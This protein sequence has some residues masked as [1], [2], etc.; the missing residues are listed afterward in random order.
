MSNRCTVRASDDAGATRCCARHKAA[1]ANSFDW[2][3]LLSNTLGVLI[4][5][6]LAYGLGLVAWRR[7]LDANDSRWEKE[8][9]EGDGQRR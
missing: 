1:C 9:K 8:R 2:S 7:E 4:G 6:V 5:G 3:G